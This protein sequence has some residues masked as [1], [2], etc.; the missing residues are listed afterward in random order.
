MRRYV[1]TTLVVALSLTGLVASSTPAA[2]A[3][4]TIQVS[5]NAG[6]LTATATSGLAAFTIA[7]SLQVSTPSPGTVRVQVWNELE[8]KTGP[9]ILWSSDPECTA[10]GVSSP[11]AVITCTATKAAV[12]FSAVAVATSTGRF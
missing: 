9:A 1:V 2:A 4:G 11:V 10:A 3:T 6:S 12:D 8:D 5:V 7:D